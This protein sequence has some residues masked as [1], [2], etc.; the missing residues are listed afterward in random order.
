MFVRCRTRVCRTTW[1]CMKVRHTYSWSSSPPCH[2][3]VLT[4]HRWWLKSNNTWVSQ[5]PTV[6]SNSWEW[7]GRGFACE[8]CR[9]P[10]K[11]PGSCR[12]NL[13]PSKH[14]ASRGTDIFLTDYRYVEL[15]FAVSRLYDIHIIVAQ[16]VHWNSFLPHCNY[17]ICLSFHLSV[18]CVCKRMPWTRSTEILALLFAGYWGPVSFRL[19]FVSF[20]LGDA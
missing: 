7:T 17:I 19:V 12:W 1:R 14:R 10:A 4:V 11:T 20:W 9:R 2:S 16:S 8:P 3:Q 18:K 5:F 15:W 6:R 13:A